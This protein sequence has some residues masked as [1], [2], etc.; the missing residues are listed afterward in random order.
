MNNKKGSIE[1]VLLLLTVIFIIL[2]MS[3]ILILYI[4][5]NS[6]IY[7]IKN[8]LFY[9]VQNAYFSLDLEELAYNNYSVNI[10]KLNENIKYL[11]NLNFPNNII[12]YNNIDYDKDN[13]CLNIDLDLIVEPLVLKDIIKNVRIN[14]KDNIKLKLM[15]VK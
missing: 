9:I 14:I 15:E 4:Q 7:V 1:I 2:I 5:I 11:L 3:I 6:N 10:E 8:D 13:K 12:I